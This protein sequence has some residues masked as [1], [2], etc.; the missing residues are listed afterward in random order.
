MADERRREDDWFQRNERE[1]LEAA[2]ASREK[3]EKERAAK[4]RDEERRRLREQHYMKCP[5]CGHDLKEEALEGINIDRCTHCEGIYLDA[6]E[7]DK[8]FLKKDSERKGLL[9]KVLG[10]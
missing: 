3:R 8:L 7:L 6:G 2:K 5:K 1:L 4:E 10:I 9:R